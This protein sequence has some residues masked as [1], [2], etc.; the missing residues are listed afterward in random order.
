MKH[1]ITIASIVFVAVGA[2]IIITNGVPVGAREIRIVTN[3][4]P[5]Y[6]YD[7]L[8]NSKYKEIMDKMDDLDKRLKKIENSR[9]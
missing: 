1:E 8:H 9:K 7:S 2:V 5:V 4:V 6:Q 3:S